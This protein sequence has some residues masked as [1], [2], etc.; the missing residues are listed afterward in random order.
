MKLTLIVTA[1]FLANFQAAASVL[2][3]EDY[4]APDQLKR[5]ISVLS[6]GNVGGLASDARTMAAFAEGI[7]A[8]QEKR[9][10]D[11]ITFFTQSIELKTEL[12]DYAEYNLG[13]VYHRKNDLEKAKQYFQ[14]VVYEKPPSLRKYDAQFA[15][16]EIAYE[17]KNYKQA[18]V[19]FSTLE[20]KMRRTEQYP[21]VLWYLSLSEM[22]LKRNYKACNWIRKIYYKYPEHDLVKDWTLDLR[23]ATLNGQNANCVASLKDQ[24][25]R[26]RQLQYAGHSEKARTEILELYK[27]TT[28]LTKFYV[29]MI[30][31]SFLANEGEVEEALKILLPH[32]E[33]RKGD[34]NYLMLMAKAAHRLGQAQTAT[35]FYLQ[36]YKIQPRSKMGK[37][38][39][40]QAA[41]V[42]YQ[43]QDYDGAIQK[44]ENYIKMFPGDR[45]YGDAT[46]YLIAWSK[47]LKR[48][49]EAA[50][51]DFTKLAHKKFRRRSY[52][53]LNQ[54]A[55]WKAVA[56]L[57]SGKTQAARIEFESLAQ[58]PMG[59]YYGIAARAR[60]LDIPVVPVAQRAV[61]ES[62]V[63]ARS[64]MN[65]LLLAQGL[66][67]S[68]MVGENVAT[69]PLI[70]ADEVDESETDEEAMSG[71]VEVQERGDAA[72]VSEVDDELAVEEDSDIQKDLLSHLKDPRL[73]MN[74]IKARQLRMLGLNALANQELHAIERRTRNKSFLKSLASEYEE[75]GA[76]HRSS[77][78]GE[79]Y[80]SDERKR[81]G[82]K[83]ALKLWERT[84]PLAFVDWITKFSKDYSVP[85]EVI[86]SV[87]R[88]ESHYKVRAISPVGAL[89]LM[90]VMPYTAKRVALILKEK[91]FDPQDLLEPEKNIRIGTRYLKRLSDMFDRRLPLVAAA[92]NA[93]PHRVG[94]WLQAFGSLDMDE[95]IDHIPFKQTR[96]YAKEIIKNYYLYKSIYQPDALKQ[97]DF[98]WLAEPV[99]VKY[100]GSI[101]KETWDDITV[102]GTDHP[103]TGW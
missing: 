59:S 39:L 7:R 94:S 56:L 14:K 92:Y 67:P 52:F 87:M 76:F 3:E 62:P 75:G 91:T 88:T 19:H 89:G 29:D 46:A 8:F 77:Y 13:M 40:F 51:K 35:A 101:A 98:K 66:A 42:S 17:Q 37:E 28:E 99:H 57:K 21:H 73:N 61:A 64:S 34:R 68:P 45:M 38:A 32:Y 80:F 44:F 95:F 58:D 10:D 93:G 41:F 97:E 15:L 4:V 11:A 26:V 48:D 74:F 43:S 25:N 24:K 36:A 103:I 31:G 69:E 1:A 86:W 79:T 83:T 55:Y 23:K 16:G 84:Y 100:A 20:R 27:R 96:N 65:P 18:L 63:P 22:G 12:R 6:K 70:T 85:R 78:I 81:G 60:L 47:Y 49:Y 2:W 50:L 54:V 33:Q 53:S 90:Q 30:Y 5:A 71:D 102:P 9:D 72:E 82:F